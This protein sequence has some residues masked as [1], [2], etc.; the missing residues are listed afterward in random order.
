[1]LCRRPRR[2]SVVE[3]VVS[4]AVARPVYS[5]R[6]ELTCTDRGYRSRSLKLGVLCPGLF[7]DGNVGVGV[8][9]QGEEILIGGAGFVGVALQRIRAGEA[10]MGEHKERIVREHVGMV[11]KFLILRRRFGALM[12]EQVC[13]PAHVRG[14]K[15]Y[16]EFQIQYIAQLMRSSGPEKLDGFGG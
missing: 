10:E 8:L 5:V 1:M 4:I 12:E 15:H 16:P 11:E 9:P 14:I 6:R 2:L 7:Q 13:L 3:G